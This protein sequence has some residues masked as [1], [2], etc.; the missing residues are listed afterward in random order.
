MDMF[1]QD[2]RALTRLADGSYGRCEGCGGADLGKARLQ[3]SP[4]D[5]VSGVQDSDRSVGEA[6]SWGIFVTNRDISARPAWHPFGMTDVALVDQT[7]AAPAPP[8]RT[9]ALTTT[10]RRR[11]VPSSSIPGVAVLLVSRWWLSD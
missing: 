9:H 10:R 1:Q 5:L 7:I 3:A 8:V 11:A 4:G 6:L 2:E